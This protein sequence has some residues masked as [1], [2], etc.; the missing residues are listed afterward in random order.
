MIN[1]TESSSFVRYFG[2]IIHKSGK[3]NFKK[4]H[5]FAKNHLKKTFKLEELP[6]LFH[7]ISSA[8]FKRE[9]LGLV[10]LRSL[11]N[12]GNSSLVQKVMDAHLIPKLISF[13]ERDNSPE[14]QINSAWVL[15]KLASKGTYEQII[16]VIDFGKIL[17]SMVRL[18]NT[19]NSNVL[20]AV[21]FLIL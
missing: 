8:D 17:E 1:H 15:T 6:F 13:L 16:S 3:Y 5:R 7:E 12:K 11:L 14:L 18:L 4:L 9:H 21:N 10:C 2:S 20:I 19:N